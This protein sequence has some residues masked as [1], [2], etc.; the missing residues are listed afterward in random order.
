[1]KIGIIKEGKFPPDARVPLA[2]NQCKFIENHFPVKVVVESSPSRCY[3]DNEYQAAGIEV[4]DNLTDCEMLM[5]VKEVPVKQLMPCKTYFFFSH[6]I[7]K[8][9]QNRQLL[10]SIL[11]KNIRLIDYEVL[12]DAAGKR[13][14]AFGKFAGMVG[15]H[16][17]L[18][19]YGQR[20]GAFQLLRMKD[21]KDYATA[22]ELY[23]SIVFPPV[24]IV[25]TGTGR[26]SAGAV[27]VLQD[28]GISQVEPEDFLEKSFNKAVF[29][30]LDSLHYVARKN[31]GGFKKQDFYEH[32]EKFV[33]AFAPY[34]KCADILVHGIYWDMRAPRFFT[35]EEMKQPDFR[36]QVIADITCDIAPDA[37]IPSTI[38][39]ST[40]AEPV[41]GFNPIVP[42]E[43]PP[44][45]K[46]CIDVMAIDN[47]PN[48][49]PRDASSAFGEQFIRFILPEL[50]KDKSP[51]IEN[52]T[53]AAEGVICKKF[54]YLHDYVFA[55]QEPHGQFA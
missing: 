33:S 8:Q 3:S 41:Y 27:Q 48:E 26:V 14:I 52:A 45:N 5:G 44:F 13:L 12:K 21:C 32:P 22:S 55:G 31:G 47:L 34:Y 39:P 24:K 53:I 30:Q 29:T 18:W 36:I 42:A 15:A 23:K 35:L 4:V 6:T 50:F 10:W 51:M 43:C 49:L 9:P 40:I 38:R 11:D 25:L 2:P 37:S 54:N 1:M 20:T 17:A 7:K 46:A 28:M 19:T 16:N